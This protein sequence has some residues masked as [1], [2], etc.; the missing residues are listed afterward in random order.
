MPHNPIPIGTKIIID[1]IHKLVYYKFYS[2]IEEAIEIE[3]LIKSG[4]RKKK[5][6][7]IQSINPEWEDLSYE[8]ENEY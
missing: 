1:W 3:K 2:R 4:S 5:E 8:I 6:D 7:L